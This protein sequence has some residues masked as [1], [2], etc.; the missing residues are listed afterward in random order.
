MQTT[1]QTLTNRDADQQAENVRIIAR[2]FIAEQRD[3][4][5]RPMTDEQ[6]EEIIDNTF[7][8]LFPDIEDYHVPVTVNELTDA[9]NVAHGL[10]V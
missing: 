4:I 7:S 8:I 6:R 1:T 9:L 10:T 2:R 5:G 3:A